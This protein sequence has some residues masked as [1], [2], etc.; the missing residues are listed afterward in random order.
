MLRFNV[1]QLTLCGKIDLDGHWIFGQPIQITAPCI[2]ENEHLLKSQNSSNN[3]HIHDHDRG[4]WIMSADVSRWVSN[5]ID[6][7]PEMR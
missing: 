3:Q 1:L 5:T 4:R 6:N 2:G 7:I